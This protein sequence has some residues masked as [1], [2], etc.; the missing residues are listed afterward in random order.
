MLEW[1]LALTDAHLLNQ[2]EPAVVL[3]N[4]TRDGI[5]Q[6]LDES[7]EPLERILRATL[8]SA[9]YRIDPWITAFPWRRLQ[10]QT[11]SFRPLG[12]Y[13]W[14]VAPRPGTPGPTAAGLLHA[15]TQAQA[16]TA[17]ILR[18]K[19]LT[20]AEP[21]RWAMSL[22]SRAIRRASRIAEEVRLGAPIQDVLGREVERIAGAKAQIEALRLK[23]PIR[24][25]HQGRRVCDG[26]AVLQ[27]DPAAA[28]L[29]PAQ[30]AQLAE[31]RLALDAYGDLLV[32]EAVH[33]VVAGRGDVASAAMD[34]AAGL[35]APPNLE[36][37]ATP[38]SGRGINS[39]VVSVLAVAS[40][41]PPADIATSPGRLADHAVADH[42]IAVLG[43]PDSAAWEWDILRADG[44]AQTVN[45][46]G[47]GFEP[48][49]AVAL[50]EDELLRLLLALVG[51]GLGLNRAWQVRDGQGAY[52]VA[53]LSDFGLNGV[54]LAGLDEGERLERVKALLPAGSEIVESITPPGR[55]A[56][57]QARRI[58]NL[59]GERPAAPADLVAGADAPADSAVRAELADRF[60]GL[61]QTA[62]LLV[63]S[64]SGLAASA[65]AAAQTE[66]L[67]RAARWG[68]TPLQG[69]GESLG[70]VVQ[71]AAESL[72][73]RLAAA[74]A[75]TASLNVPALAR[76]IAELAAPEGHLAIL[77]RIRLGDLPMQW[78]KAALDE[79]W[80]TLNAAVRAP[81][82]RLE[83]YQLEAELTDAWPKLAAW[84]NRPDDPWQQKPPQNRL[85]VLYTPEQS[86]PE[87]T[88]AAGLLDSWGEVI[89]DAEQAT[90]AAFGFNAPAARAPQAILVAVAPIPGKLLD[91]DTLLSI[92]AETRELAQ[93]RMATPDALHDYGAALP[94]TMLSLCLEPQ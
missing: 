61:A 94:M 21:K 69:E 65:D 2:T 85:I 14:V 86:L 62:Q 71:R 43:Q 91:S 46:A 8:D 81:L 42:L 6:L 87:T 57:E 89:P 52:S 30:Q 29:S 64:L 10:N 47:L 83:A 54:E 15:P 12:L 9:I 23:F 93:A 72:A 73:A 70:I 22:D 48:V 53:R 38:R 24:T 35:S 77:G 79:E 74:P 92:V 5:R 32:V 20:D 16:L 19:Y 82:A 39:S 51:D 18:D 55:L 66:A 11:A 63:D 78:A 3:Y 60:V 59:L 88:I 45:L 50:A 76:A 25:E 37:I 75:Q 90:S 27:A 34:A 41:P 13:A 58:I 44:T 7:L 17:A 1:A 80:L 84:T 56:Q 67:R 49:D 4:Q 33:H 26:L 68:I 40:D 28:G 36:A 31:L